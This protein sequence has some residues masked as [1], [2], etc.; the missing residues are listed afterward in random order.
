MDEEVWGDMPAE[1]ERRY[2]V[3]RGYSLERK[4]RDG[5]VIKVVFV[6]VIVV[7]VAFAV[8]IFCS[9]TFLFPRLN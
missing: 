2:G 6:V 9:Q 8:S 7:I 4:M 1:G 5:S 3:F